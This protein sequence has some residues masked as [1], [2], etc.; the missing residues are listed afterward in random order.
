MYFKYKQTISP[1][2]IVSL[3]FIHNDLGITLDGNTT[4]RCLGPDIILIFSCLSTTEFDRF[5]TVK[6]NQIAIL[7]AF[8]NYTLRFG[9]VVLEQ[10][11]EKS[12]RERSMEQKIA[13]TFDLLAIEWI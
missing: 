1:Q 6:W 2:S 8:Y 4:L 5:G 9:Y 13:V 7:N 12:K 11:H 3:L 10:S